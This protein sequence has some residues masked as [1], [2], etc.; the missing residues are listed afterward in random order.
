[1]PKIIYFVLTGS[2][3]CGLIGLYFGF[4]NAESNRHRLT[5]SASAKIE[6]VDVVRA[7]SPDS[8]KEY[9][10]F[11]TVRYSYIID[12]VSYTHTTKMDPAKAALFIPWDD[13]R[14]CFD[15]SDKA[16]IEGGKI[17]PKD[18]PAAN[19]KIRPDAP[20]PLCYCD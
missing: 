8:G 1:L 10:A 18:F 17:F 11:V 16:T 19:S 14:V 2:I 13:A 6:N 7:V 4:R 9:T 20:N 12:T 5:S 15:R 3:A